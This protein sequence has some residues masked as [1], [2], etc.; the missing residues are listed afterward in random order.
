M[1]DF[2]KPFRNQTGGSRPEGI[3]ESFTVQ[4]YQDGKMDIQ[5]PRDPEAI[6]E[7]IDFLQN[8]LDNL[9]QEKENNPHFLR[10]DKIRQNEE[11]IG[12]WMEKKRNLEDEL[13]K[14]KN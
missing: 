7:R 5:A 1:N 4:H 2:E 3:P 10:D 11:L 12:M 9:K 6:Q 14:S 13:L 8:E